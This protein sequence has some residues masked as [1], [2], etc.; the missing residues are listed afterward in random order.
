[1]AYTITL[2]TK[3]LEFYLRNKDFPSR[4]SIIFNKEYFKNPLIIKNI[5]LCY[6]TIKS[7]FKNGYIKLESPLTENQLDELEQ[8]FFTFELLCK[9]Q[10]FI[11]SKKEDGIIINRGLKL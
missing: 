5:C 6:N 4:P 7:I 1:M 11:D 8:K 10:L 2:N 3:K 9:W